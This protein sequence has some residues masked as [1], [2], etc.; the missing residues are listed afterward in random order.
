MPVTPKI[1]KGKKAL[2]A[3]ME[4]K[5]LCRKDWK[6]L[7]RFIGALNEFQWQDPGE[8]VKKWKHTC[9]GLNEFYNLEFIEYVERKFNPGDIVAYKD[10]HTLLDYVSYYTPDG[11][12][13]LVRCLENVGEANIFS[14]IAPEHS[15]TLI[16][17]AGGI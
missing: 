16:K 1:Y 17:R 6:R 8:K 11:C 15:L 10:T 5:I 12:V 4:G 2:D 3:L 13:V 9:I 14:H 7:Y